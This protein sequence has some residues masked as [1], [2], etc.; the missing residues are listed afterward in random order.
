[1]VSHSRQCFFLT[2]NRPSYGANA[3]NTPPWKNTRNY[4]NK[5]TISEHD[6]NVRLSTDLKSSNLA[7]FAV[8]M[9]YFNMFS[10]KKSI[11]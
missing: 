5:M 7:K 1:M 3:E 2:E 4:M 8:K 6:V 9:W 11:N 10:N